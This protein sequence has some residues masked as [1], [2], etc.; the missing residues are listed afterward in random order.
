MA[1]NNHDE[2]KARDIIN[3]IVHDWIK[4][5]NQ[6]PIKKKIHGLICKYSEK[7]T[8]SVKNHNHSF[9]KEKARNIIQK[10]R[11]NL[12]NVTELEEWEKKLNHIAQI[13][14][15]GNAILATSKLKPTAHNK[16]AVIQVPTFD[17]RI[18]AKADVRDKIHVQTN[19]STSTETTFELSNIVVIRIQLQNDFGTDDVN[20]FNRF[21]NHPF[22]MEEIP[23][24]K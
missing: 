22:V 21:L 1:G 12:L 14:I 23:C 17:Q 6:S 2:T 8:L 15:N 11:K 13:N 24:S 20:L 16:E 9:I 7:S 18:T 10:L 19:A 4:V 3:I 5:V